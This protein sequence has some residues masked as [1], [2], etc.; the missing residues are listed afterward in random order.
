M[1]D[2]RDDEARPRFGVDRARLDA[3]AAAAEDAGRAAADVAYPQGPLDAWRALVAGEVVAAPPEL[4]LR[5]DEET[6]PATVAMSWS[7]AVGVR[8]ALEEQATLIVRAAEI[9]GGQE[10][11]EHGERVHGGI[12]LRPR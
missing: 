3:L 4:S 11:D 5:V 7:P 1:S 12:A 2:E 6:F 10:P 9:A 8:D